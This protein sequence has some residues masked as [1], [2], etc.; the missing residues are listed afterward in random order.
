MTGKHTEIW[1]YP[2]LNRY[3]LVDK[4]GWNSME[5]TDGRNRKVSNLI[6]GD[7]WKNHLE[8]VPIQMKNTVY[9]I[10]IHAQKQDDF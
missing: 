8:S 7:E 2:W 9:T 3:S 4:C 5:I 10:I 1:S 6:L